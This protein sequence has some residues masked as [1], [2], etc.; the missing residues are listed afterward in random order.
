MADQ[1]QELGPARVEQEQNEQKEMW[2]LDD[3]KAMLKL[4]EILAEAKG[5]LI[6]KTFSDSGQLFDELKRREDG[7]KLPDI[8]ILD[9]NLGHNDQKKTG[10]EVLK[11]LRELCPDTL[12]QVE[13]YGHTGN[14]LVRSDFI[15]AGA[16][17][18]LL[19]PSNQLTEYIIG[20][21][22]EI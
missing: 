12:D 13:V 8:I 15:E 20:S 21:R 16:K 10:I 2:I 5:N 14:E 18:V 22:D 19:K 9:H 6:V 7:T 17:E 3:D 1:E 4:I 11:K